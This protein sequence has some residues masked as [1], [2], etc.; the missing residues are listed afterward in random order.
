MGRDESRPAAINA[1]GEIVGSAIDSSKIATDP[2]GSHAFHERG[3][4]LEDINTL[5]GPDTLAAAG[6]KVLMAAKGINDRGQI[7]GEGVTVEGNRVAYLLSPD[8]VKSPPPPTRSATNILEL[9]RQDLQTALGSM[10]KTAA[11]NKGGFVEKSI[12]DLQIALRDTADAMDD[13]KTL[14]DAPDALSTAKDVGIDDSALAGGMSAPNPR[15]ALQYLEFALADVQR[16]PATD[17]S[18]YRQKIIADIQQAAADTISSI[19]FGGTPQAGA[20]PAGP[21]GRNAAG[22]GNSGFGV[23]RTSIDGLP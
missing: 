12:A 6:F 2:T 14:P 19:T 7:V 4:S 1:T 9:T 20:A 11:N 10:Q 3:G 23:P 16:L 21:N 18:G 22:P 8:S 17:K 15:A 5:V 13:A